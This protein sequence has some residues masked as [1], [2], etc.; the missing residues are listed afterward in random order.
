MLSSDG[1]VDFQ[2]GPTAQVL[3]AKNGAHANGLEA[4]GN[5]GYLG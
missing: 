2:K 1:A 3:G 5:T 4:P